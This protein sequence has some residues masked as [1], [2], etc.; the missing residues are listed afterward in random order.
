MVSVARDRGLSFRILGDEGARIARLRFSQQ[1]PRYYL[2][3]RNARLL[4]RGAIGNFRLPSGPESLEDIEPAI[5]KFLSGNLPM[6]TRVR[7]TKG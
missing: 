3:D 4:C 2:L 5:A 1:T 7:I 6:N